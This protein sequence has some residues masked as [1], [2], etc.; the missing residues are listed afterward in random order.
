MAKLIEVEGV[1]G[2]KGYIDP[3]DVRGILPAQDGGATL[4]REQDGIPIVGRET[5]EAVASAL[6]SKTPGAPPVVVAGKPADIAELIN[7]AR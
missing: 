2:S 3:A 1:D 4:P 7:G 6:L 5:P